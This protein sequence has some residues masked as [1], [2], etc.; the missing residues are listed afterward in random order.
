MGLTLSTR[1]S[2]TA[3]FEDRTVRDQ[4]DIAAREAVE[5]REDLTLK[6]KVQINIGISGI[7][8]PGH[9]C[10]VAYASDSGTRMEAIGY[11][12]TCFADRHLV[13][14]RTMVTDF[15]FECPQM[16]RF[17][18]MRMT[19]DVQLGHISSINPSPDIP[20]DSRVVDSVQCSMADVVSRPDSRL[21]LPL[22]VA[23][24]ISVFVEEMKSLQNILTFSVS[25]VS[26]TPNKG[27]MK[28]KSVFTFLTLHR[29]ADGVS[30]D[31][32]MP[33]VIRTERVES[34]R[35]FDWVRDVEWRDLTVSVNA[36][37]RGESERRVIFKIWQVVGSRTKVVS[38]YHTDY[39]TIERA[40]SAGVVLHL[41]DDCGNAIDVTGISIDRKSSFLD[42]VAS[43]LEISL[44]VGIDFTK[45]NRDANLPDSLHYLD[46][47]GVTSNDYMRAIESVVQ[48]LEHYDSDH[49]VPVYGFGA[50]LP[51]SYTHCSHLFAC[52]GDFF[53]PEVKGVQG[54]LDA[55]KTSLKSVLLHGP[56]NFHDIVS[57]VGDE[58][59]P[60]SFPNSPPRYFILL[61][62]TDG[63]ISDLK[64]TIDEIVRAS[65]YPVSIIIVG[66]GD[67]DFGL[68][69]I[70]DGD[71]KRL[72]SN[73]LQRSA[74]RDIVQFVPFNQ[75]RNEPVYALAKETLDEIPREVVNYFSWRGVVP[76][77]VVNANST[78]SGNRL[79]QLK[80]QF[81]ETLVSLDSSLDTMRLSRV[82]DDQKLPAMD[83]EYFHDVVQNGPKNGNVFLS[84]KS[85]VAPMNEVARRP[86][87]SLQ[88]M[89]DMTAEDTGL[90]KWCKDRPID[91]ILIPCGHALF[92]LDCTDHVIANCPL[93][94]TKVA[95]IIPKLPHVIN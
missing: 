3:R 76:G 5:K 39:G 21:I 40:A 84:N 74:S 28:E 16:L 20:F 54:V 88:S 43:G 90:C 22:T 15:S 53:S 70:L 23:Q 77:T 52:N 4:V 11:T 51:P 83:V 48:I 85:N 41:S 8:S 62:L 34:T 93:C 10:I 69:N 50:R 56:T 13:F 73:G 79:S 82:L 1:R 78:Q 14:V 75:F 44:I 33:E 42:Y 60:F 47:S 95:R 67:E 17:D 92:C 72:Y 61:I 25:I 87:K 7:T 19:G 9:Y 49:M 94:G 38:S 31:S 66:V 24:S 2:T 58:A 65:D 32:L 12:E 45:S 36:L 18:V 86:R 80:T 89:S 81:R 55:Y 37:C 57:L 6:T 59:R 63:V 26:L 30:D 27:A 46:P 35:P 64:A 91:T 71:D 68:M 29:H